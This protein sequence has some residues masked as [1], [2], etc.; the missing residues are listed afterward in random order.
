[1]G[2]KKKKT[3]VHMAAKKKSTHFFFLRQHGPSASEHFMIFL[4]LQKGT[5]RV[6]AVDFFCLRR[7]NNIRKY[8]H[9]NALECI[10]YWY[11]HYF[12]DAIY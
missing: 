10:I 2:G 11:D 1:M 12:I 8:T 6:S 3:V 5:I 9:Q 4:W 7:S